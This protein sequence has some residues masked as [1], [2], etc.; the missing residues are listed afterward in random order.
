MME[1]S[2]ENNDRRK[3]T[4]KN[5]KQENLLTE[6]RKIKEKHKTTEIGRYLLCKSKNQKIRIEEKRIKNRE[7]GERKKSMV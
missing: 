5:R 3:A 6:M 1:F 2:D 7:I 4:K